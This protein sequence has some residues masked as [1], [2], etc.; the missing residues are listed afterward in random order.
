MEECTEK[1][2]WNFAQNKPSLVVDDIVARYPEVDR[3]FLYEVLLRRGVFKWFAVR[4]YLIKLKDKLKMWDV[5]FNDMGKKNKWQ[6]GRHAMLIYIKEDIRRLCHSERWNCP[7][8]DSRA[9]LW[10]RNRGGNAIQ[11]DT[12][13]KIKNERSV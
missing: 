3:D 6:K 5:G 13:S 4:R 12:V 2:I 7:D 9:K 10:L 1:N 8:N 11:F